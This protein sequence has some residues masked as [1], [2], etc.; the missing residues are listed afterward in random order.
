MCHPITNLRFKLFAIIFLFL[1]KLTK[2][3]NHIA[4]FGLDSVLEL[5]KRFNQIFVSLVQIFTTFINNV[6][7]S[8]EIMAV[9]IT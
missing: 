3:I 8:Q 1:K 7:I 5:N 4:H 2:T 9:S 6:C